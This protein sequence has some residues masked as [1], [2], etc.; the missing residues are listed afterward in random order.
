M[1]LFKEKVMN[2]L[3]MY[4]AMYTGEIET[5]ILRMTD[6]LIKHDHGFDIILVRKDGE[7]INKINSKA[8]IFF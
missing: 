3:F 8:N 5:L 1:V 7:L 2:F 4:I 6:W